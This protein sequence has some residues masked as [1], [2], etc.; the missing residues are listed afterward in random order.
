MH[1]ANSNKRIK[2]PGY[3]TLFATWLNLSILCCSL[4]MLSLEAVAR[5]GETVYQEICASCHDSGGGRIPAKS[6]LQAM[7]AKAILTALETGSMRVVG[8]FSMTGPERIAVA[9]HLSGDTYNPNWKDAVANQCDA[10]S[11]PSASPFEQPHWNGWGPG[12]VNA[13][14]Q[15]ADMARLSAADLGNLEL[16]WAF[17]FP[18]ET[19][20]ESHAS[21]VDGRLFVGSRGA[22]VY[23][24]DARSGCTHWRFD[25]DASV[26]T[27]VTISDAPIK[28]KYLAFFGDIGGAIYAVDAATGELVWKIYGDAH[29]AARTIGGFQYHEGDLYIPVSSLEEG[30]AADPNYECCTF[31]ASLLK[32]DAATGL[33]KWKT[34][35]INEPPKM[36]GKNASGRAMWGPSGAA[37]WSTPTL[38]LKRGLV[39]VSTGDNYSHPESD[40]SDSIVALS[41]ENGTVEWFY[42][43]LTGDVFTA[44]CN[45]PDR[46][47]CPKDAGPDHDMGASSMLITL[48]SGKEVL[49][50]GQK[51]G[52]A[53]VLDPDAQGKLLWQKKIAGGGILGGIEWGMANN[54][55][56]AF[57]SKSDTEWVNQ[58]FISA[59]TT[60]D[61]H[62]GGGIAAID[63][64][65]GEFAWQAPAVSCEGRTRCSPSQSAAVTAIPGAV[66]S[67]SVSGVMRAFDENTGEVLWEFDSSRSYDTANGAAGKGGAIDGP[68][69]V[70]V[71]GWVYF[72]S[73]YS[74]WGAEGG[75]VLLAF[76]VKK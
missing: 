46:T 7:S 44:A 69:V 52:V 31:R 63:L 73:G 54:G 19:V 70:V 59:T 1:P 58:E 29:P 56:Y 21:V 5:D 28:G 51:T 26:K 43:G 8:I 66:F 49:V 68:G 41:M 60:I 36:T 14:F 6:A 30:S 42:K 45:L 47:N 12:L 9:E 11:W 57:I 74:K 55:R 67:G 61:P 39:Y 13:R 20:M 23:S 72:G 25:T 62:K 53:H 2:S 17:A 16:Q 65:S 48:S 15:P 50:A 18:G 75:N 35:V 4:S 76:K 71:D 38:D 22:A 32:V 33:V 10:E 24:L 34:Y 64:Q 27:A 37:I 3:R 40:M